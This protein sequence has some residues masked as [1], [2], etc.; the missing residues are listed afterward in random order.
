V[1]NFE[2][3]DEDESSSDKNGGPKAATMSVS[4]SCIYVNANSVNSSESLPVSE[5][6]S[7]DENME[8]EPRSILLS[9]VKQLTIGMDLHRVTLPTFV[10][11]NFKESSFYFKCIY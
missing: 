9:L 2:G 4:D 7:V 3:M 6:E 11:G 10:L 1:T 8:D 5:S